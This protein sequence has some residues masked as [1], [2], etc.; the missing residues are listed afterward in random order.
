MRVRVIAVG[1][2]PPAWVREA[3]ADYTRRLGSRLKVALV[4][5]EPGPR[6]AGQSPRKAIE[7]EARKL[8]TALRPDEWVVSLDE[9]GTQMSTRELA[10][11]LAGRMQEGR[12]LAFLIGGPDG[13]APEVLARSDSSLSLSRLTLPHALVRV[14]LAEQLYRAVSIMARHPYHRDSS[15]S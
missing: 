11:W 14:V 13:F 15:C 7:A 1:T 12:D 4:E 10:D 6:S 2:R 8:M 5:I 9:R 3:Y